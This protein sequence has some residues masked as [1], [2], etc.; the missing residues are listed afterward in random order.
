MIRSQPPNE[1]V[2][3][4]YESAWLPPM[5]GTG[6]WDC[7]IAGVRFG[8]ADGSS[9]R[10]TWSAKDIRVEALREGEQQQGDP[11]SGQSIDVSTR[12]QHL[13]GQCIVAESES[14]QFTPS[15]EAV[16]ARNF[17]FDSGARI[18]IALGEL[19]DGRVSYIPDSLVVTDS[20]TAAYA[21]RPS[22]AS[23]PAWTGTQGVD[24]PE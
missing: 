20:P 2:S 5:V 16:W 24:R 14:R 7:D 12:W 10:F 4:I 13:L 1:L 8:F 22:A 6:D 17:H 15:G 9:R 21:Y 11:V 19:I 23:S 3:V 18:V